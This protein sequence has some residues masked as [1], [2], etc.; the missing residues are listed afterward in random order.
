MRSQIIVSICV[1]RVLEMII[2]PTFKQFFIVIFYS[3]N[4]NIHE[5]DFIKCPGI[6]N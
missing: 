5:K 1:R 3:T 2:I 4:K 6:G